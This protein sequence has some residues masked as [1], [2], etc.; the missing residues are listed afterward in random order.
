MMSSAPVIRHPDF[1]KVFELACDASRYGIG[2]VSSQEG[3][4]I[5]FL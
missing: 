1:I 5:A 4:P 2:G 3:H